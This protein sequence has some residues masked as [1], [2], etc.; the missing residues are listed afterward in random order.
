MRMVRAVCAPAAAALAPSTTQR[1]SV[2]PAEA[3]SACA[4]VAAA[5]DDFDVPLRT[6]TCYSR[7]QSMIMDRLYLLWP[8]FGPTGR[9]G[10]ARSSIFR[11]QTVPAPSKCTLGVSVTEYMQISGDSCVVMSYS[12][13]FSTEWATHSRGHCS[14]VATMW[15]LRPGARRIS[16]GRPVAGCLPRSA[17][18]IAA[19]EV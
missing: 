17:T 11:Y 5:C 3:Q 14:S 19:E 4:G 8:C 12:Y 6:G 2:H 16:P 1:A 15:G 10:E 7:Q 18:L 13:V 9:C